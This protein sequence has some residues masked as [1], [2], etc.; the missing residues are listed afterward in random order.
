MPKTTITPLFAPDAARYMGMTE[1][2]LRKA[3]E[4]GDVPF[5]RRGRRIIL[6]QEELSSYLDQ[7]P[8]RRLDEVQDGA[9]S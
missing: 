9:V 5:R 1:G 7:L 8:G 2:A 3:I 4:R 6:I